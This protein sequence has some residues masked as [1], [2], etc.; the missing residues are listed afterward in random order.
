MHISA[1]CSFHMKISI[2]C[3]YTC[4]SFCFLPV[5]SEILI[6]YSES[7]DNRKQTK[8]RNYISLELKPIILG[9]KMKL[10]Y[11]PF[12]ELVIPWD[13][14]I[15]FESEKNRNNTKKIGIIPYMTETP[16]S[17]KA[18]K[19]LKQ[20][21]LDALKASI[22]GFG[23]LKP[24]AVAE[25]PEDLSFFFGKGKY[26]IVDGQRRYLALKELLKLPSEYDE[27]KQ[28]DDIRKHSGDDLIEKAE[29][30]AQQQLEKLSIRDYVLVPCLIYPYRTY[31]QMVRHS[32]E[33]SKFGKKPCKLFLEIVENMRQQ[34]IPDL[35]P[36]DL[37]NLWET[38]DTLGE[39]QQA[40]K[41]T[42]QEIRNTKKER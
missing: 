2:A 37:N 22:G 16:D 32:T 14:S 28:N 17:L 29:M 24:F 5:K 36:D 18:I 9:K 23:L 30:Q 8:G 10:Q 1:I 35:G 11:I 27:R 31:L 40:I 39:E 12:S 13:P 4:F 26:A 20:D 38:R 3:T 34:G 15:N 25:L 19:T 7:K 21:K 6:C 41:D 42:L 33:D